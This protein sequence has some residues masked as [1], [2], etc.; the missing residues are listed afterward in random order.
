M[1]QRIRHFNTLHVFKTSG[2]KADAA[3]CCIGH[4]LRKRPFPDTSTDALISVFMWIAKLKV[5]EISYV[6]NIFLI[7]IFR[8]LYRFGVHMYQQPC[9]SKLI[10]YCEGNIRLFLH[11]FQ[12]Q[13][14]TWTNISLP[15]FV[16]LPTTEPNMTKDSNPPMF[17]HFSLSNTNTVL[18]AVYY[19]TTVI[20]PKVFFNIRG[21]FRCLI[22]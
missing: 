21:F 4:T 19:I 20:F 8:A 10:T 13:S 1:I 12:V 6:C 2:L 11:S 18:V 3:V 7:K 14:V 15:G 9:S 22:S 16:A 5:R 17:K